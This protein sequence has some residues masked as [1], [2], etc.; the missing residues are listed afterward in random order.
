MKET[1]MMMMMISDNSDDDDDARGGHLYF[2]VDI[3]RVKR[4]SKST[5]NTYFSKCEN[6]P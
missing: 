3:I 4:L 6:I 2:K 5:L 1:S